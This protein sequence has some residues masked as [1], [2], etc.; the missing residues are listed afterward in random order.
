VPLTQA[1]VLK[2]ESG[3]T[4]DPTDTIRTEKR[5]DDRNTVSSF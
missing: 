2:L 5:G 3:K 4:F 1:A